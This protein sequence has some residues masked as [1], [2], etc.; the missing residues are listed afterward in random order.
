V[1]LCTIYCYL[2]I[3]FLHF[4]VPLIAGFFVAGFP[5]L[6]RF[7]AHHDKILTKMMPKL[8]RHFDKHDVD[9]GLYTLKWYFQCFLDRV[10]FDLALRLWDIYLLEGENVMVCAAYTILKVH[11][12][13]LLAKKNMDDILNHLQSKIPSDFGMDYDT[14]ILAYQKCTDELQTKNLHS[15]GEAGPEEFPSKP[16][17]LVENIKKPAPVMKRVKVKSTRTQQIETSFNDPSGRI[18][19]PNPGNNT[20][21]DFNSSV[22][23]E[24]APSDATTIEYQPSDPELFRVS[25]D[26]SESRIISHGASENREGSVSEETAFQSQSSMSSAISNRSTRT[27]E[28]EKLVVR[29]ALNSGMVTND[30]NVSNKKTKNGTTSWQNHGIRAEQDLNLEEVNVSV[31]PESQNRSHQ[32]RSESRAVNSLKKRGSPPPPPPRSPQL[33]SRVQVNSIGREHFA[34]NISQ[35]HF[36]IT[37][38][39]QISSNRGKL[40]NESPS[41]RILVNSRG[42]TPPPVSPRKSV[43]SFNSGERHIPSNSNNNNCSTALNIPGGEAVRIHVP[44]DG[45]NNQSLNRNSNT[46][47]SSNRNGLEI[48]KN[49]PNRIKIDVPSV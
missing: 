46:P 25:S 23:S 16:F 26:H 40:E 24:I 28:D 34:G 45:L 6:V 18:S 41:S 35:S 9:S 21:Q 33:K 19:D 37:H 38:S 1:R 32:I 22:V 31:N 2:S 36:S 20:P 39:S 15:A 48:S 42:S 49:D 17:G 3:A 13:E 8:K 44:Y 7:Q 10:P 14:A 43:H 12:K 5:K 30:V 29:S 47:T 4:I 27:H 11:R